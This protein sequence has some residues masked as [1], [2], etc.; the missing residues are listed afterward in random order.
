MFKEV[1][2][3]DPHPDFLEESRS[4]ELGW[5][6]ANDLAGRLYRAQ[7]HLLKRPGTVGLVASENFDTSAALA[8]MRRTLKALWALRDDPVK[9]HHLMRAAVLFSFS[10]S[11]RGRGCR[12][13]GWPRPWELHQL[14]H[15]ALALAG[16]E[17][18][19]PW[20]P[21]HT[22][23]V[24]LIYWEHDSWSECLA[25]SVEADLRDLTAFSAAVDHE[26]A[27]RLRHWQP[28]CVTYHSEA[29]PELVAE[30]QRDAVMRAEKEAAE[31]AAHREVARRAQA[32][33]ARLLA[34]KRKTYPRYGEWQDLDADEL[35]RLVWEKTLQR[36]A[37]DFGVSNVG[38]KKRCKAWGIPTPPQ[39]YWLRQARLAA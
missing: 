11:S 36:V 32:E 22:D 7:A 4:D 27:L 39:G 15:E 35:Q 24:P 20:D 5:W 17:R 10:G 37:Q 18:R 8:G 25:N 13:D 31:W 34:E 9:Q 28:V 38:V 3:R 12:F 30:I 21:M 23:V 33:A 6:P 29:N 16:L 1:C 14:Y 26:V 2:L 19:S